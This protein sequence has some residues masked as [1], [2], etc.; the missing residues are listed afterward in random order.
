MT[1]MWLQGRALLSH[2]VA[3][4]YLLC[5]MKR[6][7]GPQYEIQG[8][9]AKR[10]YRSLI[11]F[12]I[13]SIDYD[14]DARGM[15][16]AAYPLSAREHIAAITIAVA[17]L[18]SQQESQCRHLLSCNCS[19]TRHQHLNFPSHLFLSKL[20]KTKRTFPN[21]PCSVHWKK[22]KKHTDNFFLHI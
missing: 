7:K 18:L 15:L 21:I 20:S 14:E 9:S 2:T 5:Y 4:A 8:V 17:D 10:R 13:L 19:N 16:H 11:I 22:Y 6:I 1:N 3:P 12:T